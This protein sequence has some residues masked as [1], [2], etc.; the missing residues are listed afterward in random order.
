MK[1][2]TIEEMYKKDTE[3]LE[4]AVLNGEELLE[5]IDSNNENS[6][7]DALS[8]LRR[9]YNAEENDDKKMTR[10]L[11]TSIEE[12]KKML[13]SGYADFE[14]QY[15]A[16]K[17]INVPVNGRLVSSMSKEEYYQRYFSK[18]IRNLCRVIN[19]IIYTLTPKQTV[20]QKVYIKR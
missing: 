10:D 15:Q 12:S 4:E 7:I 1:N 20:K 16:S 18:R 17:T 8:E 13:E 19:N 3:V 2:T 11:Q 14:K 9:R 6:Y 5:N